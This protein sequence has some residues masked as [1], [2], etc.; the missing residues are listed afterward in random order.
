VKNI[1]SSQDFELATP[2][3]LPML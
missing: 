3:A 2:L 1:G